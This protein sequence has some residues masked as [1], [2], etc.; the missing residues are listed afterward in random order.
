MAH[1]APV[2]PPRA[3]GDL[4]RDVREQPRVVQRHA[5]VRL[6]PRCASTVRGGALQGSFSLRLAAGFAAVSCLGCCK[7]PCAET[8][9]ERHAS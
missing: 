7:L 8:T 4:R 5:Q 3:P 2:A 6:Q 1:D 9:H